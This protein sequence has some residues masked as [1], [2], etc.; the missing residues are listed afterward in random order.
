MDIGKLDKRI[1]FCVLE[2]SEND[3]GQSVMSPRK[4]RSVWAT[5]KPQKGKEMQEANKLNPELEIVIYTRYYSFVKADMLIMY[6]GKMLEIIAPPVD[7]DEQHEFLHIRC[8][9]Y[10]KKA[11]GTGVA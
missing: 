4:V 8:A 5:V 2:E 7:K 1:T 6:K 10:A 3:L 11:G 9:E